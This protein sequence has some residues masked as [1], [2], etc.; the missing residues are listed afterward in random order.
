MIGRGERERGKPAVR[1]GGGV[2]RNRGRERDAQI[3]RM[4]RSSG[5]N[6]RVCGSECSAQLRLSQ[7]RNTCTDMHAHMLYQCEKIVTKLEECWEKKNP[8]N[9]RSLHFDCLSARKHPP[10]RNKVRLNGL[11]VNS[12]SSMLSVLS[13]LCTSSSPRA[14]LPFSCRRSDSAFGLFFLSL[15]FRDFFLQRTHWS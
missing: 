11:K 5:I 7:Q 6:D 14:H 1:W 12:S 8:Q 15:C 3:C 4:S 10:K 2:G 9:I 13:F